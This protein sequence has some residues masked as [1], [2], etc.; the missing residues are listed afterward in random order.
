[1]Q[2]PGRPDQPSEGSN[3]R[4]ALGG[5]ANEAGAVHRAGIAALVTVHGL[6]GEGVPWLAS[7]TPPVQIH[8]EAD[9]A[10]DDIVVRFA[11]G[12]RAFI[13]AKASSDLGAPFKSAVAQWCDAVKA[14]HCNNG[15]QLL[16]IVAEPAGTLRNIARHLVEYQ[17]GAAPTK[18]A[19]ENLKMLRRL[20]TDRGLDKEATERVLNSAAVRFIDARH[21]GPDEGQGAAW[22]DAAVVQAGRGTAAFAMLRAAL[23]D[24]AASRSSSSDLETWRHW[25]SKAEIPLTSDR[26]GLLAAR[27]QAEDDTISAYRNRAAQNK[28]MLPLADLNFGLSSLHIPGLAAGLKATPISAIAEGG[29][30]REKEDLLKIVRREGRMV[31]VGLPGAG[32]SVALKL[33]SAEW[34]TRTQAPFPVYIRISDIASKIP[35]GGP[36]SLTLREIVEVATQGEDPILA[37]AIMRRLQRGEVILLLDALDEVLENRDAAVEAIAQLL[38]ELPPSADMIVTTRHSSSKAAETLQLPAFEL[39][40]PNDLD[41]TLDTLLQKLAETRGTESTGWLDERRDYIED[42]RSADQ[43]LWQIPLLATLM[44]LLLVERAPQSMPDSRAALLVEII[45][46]SVHRW[47]A[48]RS[49]TGIPGITVSLTSQVLLDCYDDI[50]HYVAQDRAQWND[51]SEAIENRLRDYWGKSPGEAKAAAQGVLNHWDATAGVFITSYPRGKLVARTRLFAEIGEARWALRSAT[52]AVEWLRASVG[53]PELRECVRLAAGLS[54]SIMQ[55]LCDLALKHEGD[56]LDLALSAIED[57]ARLD[58]GRGHAL[59]AVLISQISTLPLN[60]TQNKIGKFKVPGYS[61]P[62]KLAVRLANINLNDDELQLLC[63]RTRR[64]GHWQSAVVKSI[65]LASQAERNGTPLTSADLDVFEQALFNPEREE[66]LERRPA[67]LDR[68]VQFALKELLPQR[69]AAAFRVAATAYRCSMSTATKVEEQLK[70]LGYGDVLDDARPNRDRILTAS[71]RKAMKAISRFDRNGIFH[72]LMKLDGASTDRTVVRD[73]HLDEAAALVQ[74]LDINYAGLGMLDHAVT[75]VPDITL[76]LCRSIAAG[77]GIDTQL[78]T[79]ELKSLQ[80]ENPS[81]PDWFILV[82]P[83][84]R[85]SVPESSLP[86]GTPNLLMQAFKTNNEWLA[87][88]AATLAWDATDLTDDWY[89]QAIT[90]C[91]DL[92]PWPRRALSTIVAKH[93]P[94]SP[95]PSDAVSRSGYV[96]IAAARFA[97]QGDID[98]AAN[99]LRD[100]DLLVRQSAAEIL[101]KVPTD[102]KGPFIEA[103]ST[104][105]EQWTCI[106]CDRVNNIRDTACRNHHAAPSPTVTD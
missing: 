8:L 11:D 6:R 85:R 28:D 63:D 99:L 43:Y 16:L 22:L 76:D 49:T 53:D 15:D 59:K 62:A 1:M 92:A 45:D 47:E 65:A 46:A 69:E 23:R 98:D 77:Y 39:N 24:E 54:A 34:A 103:L 86:T 14:G 96:R 12:S 104:P 88:L 75:Q 74:A 3:L 58:A 25:L 70:R 105:A 101:T 90:I 67:G 56:L 27:L 81:H 32:K 40:E 38:K 48:R 91:Q 72:L 64:L 61:A 20:I 31:L 7:D 79:A 5:A 4:G 78:V 29:R 80:N 36:Y 55:S 44:V 21:L 51:V 35:R 100:P 26:D 89:A 60:P 84:K 87:D 83:S 71:T 17:N 97:Y 73:W 52:Q 10:V 30:Q 33:V 9:T 42:S 41:S 66:D 2:S 106:H 94:N 82:V 19:A 93:W 95:A 50:A 18:A 37:D 68:V 102:K 57:G 13:Q